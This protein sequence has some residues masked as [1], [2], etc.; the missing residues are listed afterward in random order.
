MPDGA[1]R[2]WR[3]C[4][5]KNLDVEFGPERLG[6]APGENGKKVH[7]LAHIAGLDD[8]RVTGGGLDLGFVPC[9]EAGRADDMNDAGLGRKS[10]EGDGRG[11]GGEVEHAVDMGEDGEGIVG[12]GDA[13]RV[14][15]GGLA[16]VAADMG[17]ALGLDSARHDA[18]RRLGEHPGQR[19]AHAPARPQHGDSHVAHCQ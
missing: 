9:G 12:D 15:A 11:R 18:S 7:A 3:W 1:S 13:E 8:G 14:K 17:R 10:G 6:D 19:L 4:I 2:L 5:S 16:E